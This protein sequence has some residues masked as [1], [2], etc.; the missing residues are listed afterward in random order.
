M[1]PIAVMK[2]FLMSAGNIFFSIQVFEQETS[3]LFSIIPGV[4]EDG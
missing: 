4:Y 1:K 2:Y 3:N